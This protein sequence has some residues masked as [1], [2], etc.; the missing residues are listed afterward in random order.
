MIKM[1]RIGWIFALL[2]LLTACGD[3]QK[4]ELNRMLLDMADKDELIDAS[5]W[6][7]L[8]EF[9]DG[10]KAHFK[11]FYKDGELDV[12][13]VKDY[14]EEYFEN[15]RP[16]KKIT[17]MAGKRELGVNFYL[18]RSGSMVPYDA[19][20]GD[21]S[22]KAAIVQMLNR[23][24]GTNDDNKIF[25]VNSEINEYPKGFSQF[26]SDAKIIDKRTRTSNS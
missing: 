18:E 6:E 25:V 17:V 23:L 20:G 15:R 16:P 9:F 19:A 22:F 5:E 14:I 7:Q 24:P 26:L 3:G 1:N 2:L 10:Q 21:G 4:K 11:D 13:E 8:S 12:D